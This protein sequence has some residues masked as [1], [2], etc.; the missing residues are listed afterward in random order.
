MAFTS[1]IHNEQQLPSGGFFHFHR[2]AFFS[3]L[4]SKNGNLLAKAAAFRINLN[5]DGTPIASK[6][7][8][9]PSHS[10]NLSFVNLVFIFRCSSS[11]TN[12]VYESRVNLLVLV[13][14]LSLHRHSYIGFICNTRFIDHN[15]Q[16]FVFSLHRYPFLCIL[17][18]SRFTC[19]NKY[20][21]WLFL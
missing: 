17:F 7:H 11:T 10:Q 19:Y 8:T 20:Y 6:S 2:A 21:S 13:C 16:A 3:N 5:L 12:P 4:K 15:K 14:S 9:H 1:T 18:N